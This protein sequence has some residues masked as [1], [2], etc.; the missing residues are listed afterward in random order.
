MKSLDV[1]QMMKY[2]TRALLLVVGLAV[3]LSTFGQWQAKGAR[4]APTAWLAEIPT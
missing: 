3:P 1:V 4:K 2:Y